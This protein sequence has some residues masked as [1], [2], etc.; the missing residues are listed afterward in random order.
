MAFERL[1]DG[2]L[3]TF[4]PG[5]TAE[6]QSA[7]LLSMVGE[8]GREL[9]TLSAS[10]MQL[11]VRGAELD[12]AAVQG[13]G[14]GAVSLPSYPFQ[15]QRCWFHE[16][17][18]T[19]PERGETAGC[20]A[21]VEHVPGVNPLLGARLDVAGTSLVYETDLSRFPSLADHRLLGYS[22]FPAAGYLELMLA[23]GLAAAGRTLDVCDLRLEQA[24]RW[25][26]SRCTRV[27]VA[28]EPEAAAADTYRCQISHRTESG[29][30]R[31]AT[32]RLASFDAATTSDPVVDQP[33]W[34]PQGTERS[35]P[36]HYA[37]CE[38]AGLQYAGPFRSLRSLCATDACA[39]GEVQLPAA[40]GDEGYRLHPA[41]LDA[42][43]QSVAPLLNPVGLWLPAAIERYHWQAGPSQQPEDDALEALRVVARVLPSEQPDLRRCQ[44]YILDQHSKCIATVEN[45]VL[46]FIEPRKP[47]ITG[48]TSHV[49]AVDAGIAAEYN[50][51]KSATADAGRIEQLTG[52]LRRRLAE[53]MDCD[54][55]EVTADVPLESLGLDSMMAFELLDDLERNLGMKIP[56]ERFLGGITL[57]EIVQ[58]G[59]D[60][61]SADRV[62][63]IEAS[64]APSH[65]SH[66]DW[67]EGAL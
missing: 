66:I 36:E 41:L 67:V 47:L 38:L 21:T 58:H 51:A 4:S 52:Y 1:A 57:A 27:Q 7:R 10:L 49:Q 45:L 60:G 50:R 11:Y 12:W 48:Q 37:Q 31:Q 26:P 17:Q 54:V 28:L 53:I 59:L 19:S 25:E 63:R 23:A 14:R 35:I 2:P 24:L 61:S 6:I 40:G 46:K 34:S 56:M 30:Q 42:C 13:P 39:W 20:L 8:P 32:C 18:P 5:A 29:W 55:S 15:R 65:A 62:P 43:L 16:P 9:A 64:S 33:L 3:L 44:L 22:V